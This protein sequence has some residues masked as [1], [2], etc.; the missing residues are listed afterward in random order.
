[1]IIMKNFFL[2]IICNLITIIAGAQTI[3]NKKFV[4]SGIVHGRD[5]GFIVLR[6][7]NA[8]CKWVSDTTYL[9]NAR[10]RFDG[11]I[12]EP[13]HAAIS[14]KKKIIDFDEV[15]YVSIFLEPDS[16][17]IEL[18]ENDY[19]H[20]KVIGSFTQQQF[21]TFN[22]QIDSINAKY[23][24][25]LQQLTAAKY[26]YQNAKTEKEKE[27]ALQEENEI[28]KKLGPRADEIIHED[29]VFILHHPD[30]YVSPYIFYTPANILPVDSAKD[31]FQTLTPRIQNSSNGKYIAAI[32]RKKEQN[33]IGKT[34]YNFE[35]KDI[36]S[37]DVSISNFHGKYLFIDFWASWCAPC[38]AEIP[39][40]KELYKQYHSKG[41]DVLSI[42]IDQDRSAWRKAVAKEKISDWYNILANEEIA[43]NY[44]NVNDAIPSGILIG[45]NG[46]IIWKSGKDETLGEVLKRLIK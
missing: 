37:K 5:T 16:Q 34:P 6:Y 44:P 8:S 27:S 11:E 1:M 38:I 13:T 4:L 10:F 32:L 28:A 26:V 19:A 3:T 25:L 9:K 14:G 46:K 43:N 41:F 42:S 20:A 36:N 24:A 29:I 15:N 7:T 35:A 30:S 39:H 2:L 17:Y 33:T 22:I 40:I 31:L 21:D 23:K 45:P 18:T 12:N